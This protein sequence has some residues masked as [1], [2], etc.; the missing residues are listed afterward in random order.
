MKKVINKLNKILDR[1]QK[2][3]ICLLFFMMIIGAC[4]EAAGVSMIIPLV[5]VIMDPEAM[6]SNW[7]LLSVCTF[8]DITEYRTFVLLCIVAMILVFLVKNLFLI[9]QTHLRVNFVDDCK[10]SAQKK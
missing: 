8:F 1:K 9:I 3:K 6:H 7:I 4:L 5:S 2:R 10:F